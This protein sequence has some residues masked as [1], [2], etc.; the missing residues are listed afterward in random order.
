MKCHV[1]DTGLSATKWYVRV[2]E[3]SIKNVRNV[4]L[5]AF[6]IK[7]K[8]NGGQLSCLPEAECNENVYL[9]VMFFAPRSLE[10]DSMSITS[11]AIGVSSVQIFFYRRSD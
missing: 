8:K 2:N 1:N 6:P 11:S 9:I 3:M 7:C 5:V 4:S 10:L